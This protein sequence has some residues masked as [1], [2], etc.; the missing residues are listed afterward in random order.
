MPTVV[1]GVRRAPELQGKF[2]PHG[3]TVAALPT[4]FAN[5][6]LNTGDMYRAAV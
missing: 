4:L 3:E 5:G 2:G 6:S 1:I